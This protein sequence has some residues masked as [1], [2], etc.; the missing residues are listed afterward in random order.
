MPRKPRHRWVR[1]QLTGSAWSAPGLDDLPG[2]WLPPVS[3]HRRL[4]GPYTAAGTIVRALAPEALTRFPGL[5]ADHGVEILSA[6]PELRDLVKMDHAL[7]SA[8]TPDQETTRF[9]SRQ[10]TL[11]LAHGLAEFLRDYAVASCE[12]PVSLI[13]SH[14]DEADHTDQE[15][16]AVLLRRLDPSVITLV[17]GTAAPGSSQ[18]PADGVLALS[19]ATFAEIPDIQGPFQATAETRVCRATAACTTARTAEL[20]AAYIAEDCLG[21]G[22]AARVAYELIPDSLRRQLHDQRA[23]ELAAA[24]EYSLRLGAI[25]HHR[26]R[27][28][29]P[30]LAVAALREALRHC[31]GLG[32][33]E[34][35]A[36]LARR[37]RALADWSA[38]PDTRYWFTTMLATASISLARP[39]EAEVLYDEIRRNTTDPAMHMSAAYAT[40]IL[41][42]RHYPQERRDHQRARGWLNEA[43]AIATLLPDSPRLALQRVFNKVG[44]ALIENHVGNWHAA[45]RLVSEGLDLLP[46]DADQAEYRLQRSVLHLR[47]VQSYTGL[48]QLESA[49]AEYRKVLEADPDYP[50]YHVD[51]GTMLRGLGRDDEALAE[52]ESAIRLSP[53]FA[54]AYYNRAEIRAAR[55]DLKGAAA[56]YG[57][58][59]EL[60][61]DTVDAHINLAA[62]LD[63]LG[64][65][66]AAAAAVDRG[67]AIAPGNAHLLCIR[68]SVDLAARRFGTAKAALDAAV[69]SDP[70]LAEAWAGRG[71]LAFETG[72]LPGALA[73]LSRAW[74]LSEDA[75][76][77]FN[78][79]VVHQALGNWAEAISDFGRVLE[80]DP[81]EEEALRR[82]DACRANLG[83][84]PR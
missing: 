68:G 34:A 17:V 42:T 13:V 77:L 48:G 23:A 50:E 73:S 70:R 4:R 49:V 78:R 26:E 41:L 2:R 84:T 30:A 3:A 83:Q 18:L 25:P 37:G 39:D 38:D 65:A 62:A 22:P 10:R 1:A 28:G 71:M 61:P 24:D 47:R 59:I 12:T 6:A 81:G 64:D 80:E 21:T 9:F 11:R 33:F 60:A 57:Y 55:G 27:G 46:K 32:F 52:Y 44:V 79:A 29:D 16:I 74:E 31:L 36:D 15:F 19:L 66:Q 67:L 45:L 82:L 63:D 8:T 40:G 14:L 75:A 69:A 7:G 76:V 43:I 5:V 51:L 56:D 72:D 35:A 20:A 54:E 58:V 53:P